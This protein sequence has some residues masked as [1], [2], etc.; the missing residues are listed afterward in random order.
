MKTTRTLSNLEFM[1]VSNKVKNLLLSVA[2][3]F[4]RVMMFISFIEMAKMSRDLSSV[5]AAISIL[6]FANNQ[7]SV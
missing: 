3:A 7:I 2:L 4:V 1:S 6:N 5:Y